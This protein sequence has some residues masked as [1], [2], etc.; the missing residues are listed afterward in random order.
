MSPEQILDGPAVTAATDIFA[1]GAVLAFA[2]T[3]RNAFA[4]ASVPALLY[5]IVHEEP[6]LD[7]VP[8]ELGLKD[9]IDACLD[10]P[11]ATAPMPPRYSTALSHP[12][13]RPGGVTN[14][15]VPWWPTPS[16]RRTPARSRCR[17]P[18]SRCRAQPPPGG[19]SC[20]AA[21]P[22]RPAAPHSSAC[23]A[24]RWRRAAAPTT[25]TTIRTPGR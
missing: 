5:R 24:T 21:P 11:P 22:W 3:G 6:E 4:A 13:R 17:L 19:A 7:D 25:R 1:L 15:C 2:A 23:S 16:R 9:L 14:H 10:K 8:V 12:P 20:P 18:P